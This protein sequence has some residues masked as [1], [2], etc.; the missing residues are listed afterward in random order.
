MRETTWSALV[1]KGTGYK[2][3]LQR[4]VEWRV[5]QIKPACFA[6]IIFFHIYLVCLWR[7]VFLVS[8][9]IFVMHC[10]I[11]LVVIW[12]RE[13]NNDAIKSLYTYSHLRIHELHVL[14]MQTYPGR[15]WPCTSR[16]RATVVQ[17]AR[18]MWS[19]TPPK[20]RTRPWRRTTRTLANDTLRVCLVWLVH[21]I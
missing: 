4:Y 6:F 16:T 14:S 11:R 1:S 5:N 15:S 9:P 17:A 18:R 2:R 13:M 21:W 7:V 19:S 8:L 20:P 3:I 10:Y 12:I